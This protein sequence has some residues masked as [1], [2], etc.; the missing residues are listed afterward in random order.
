LSSLIVINL[1]STK[2]RAEQKKAMEFAHTVRASL[3][4]ALVGEWTFDDTSN[5]GKDT[6]GYENHGTVHGATPV[7]GII[8]GA[9]SFDG[10]D[11][12]VQFPYDA[13]SQ[14]DAITI[15]Y[16]I[17]LTSDPNTSGANNWRWV[18]SPSGWQAPCHLILEQNRKTTFSVRVNGSTYRHIGGIFCSEELTV[19][20]WTHLVYI[21]NP[22]D[23]WGYAYKNGEL[24]RSGVMVPGGGNLDDSG[25]GWRISWPSG[26]SFPSGNGCIPGLIDEVRIYNRVLTAVEIQKHYAEGAVRHGIVLK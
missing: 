17:K 12:Y 10:V 11:D 5:L 19:G 24:S 15:E 14:P 6:S 23:G 4:E 13:S 7:D 1:K 25:F 2:E 22:T 21:Y 16:W 20:K 8:R 9:L 3:G 18:I 26:T